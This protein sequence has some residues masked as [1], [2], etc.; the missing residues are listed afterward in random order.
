MDSVENLVDRT[1]QEILYR[2]REL[3]GAGLIPEL[4]V[5]LD[6]PMAIDA[7]ELYWRHHIEHH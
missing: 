5:S 4:S 2:L 1:T 7:T 3:Q 6:S